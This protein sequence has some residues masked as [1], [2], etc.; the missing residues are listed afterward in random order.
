MFLLCTDPP[1]IITSPMNHVK[2]AQSTPNTLTCEATSYDGQ[3]L[4]H[5]EKKGFQETE[6]T[7]LNEKRSDGNSYTTYT[8]ISEQYRCVASNEAGETRSRIA[9][10]TIL[11][12]IDGYFDCTRF[13]PHCHFLSKYHQS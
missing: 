11:S 12:K 13:E 2:R 4:Y 6:W 7:V 10:V 5:W 1:V 9:N 3:V 8:T